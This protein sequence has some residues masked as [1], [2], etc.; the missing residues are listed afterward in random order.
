MTYQLPSR[1]CDLRRHLRHFNLLLVHLNHQQLRLRAS[2]CLSSS[3]SSWTGICHRDASFSSLVL[4][5]PYLNSLFLQFIPVPHALHE[6]TCVLRQTALISCSIWAPKLA[7]ARARPGSHS[8]AHYLHLL[9]RNRAFLKRPSERLPPA[10]LHLP[11]RP[12]PILLLPLPLEHLV[13]H[14]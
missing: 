9:H 11:L 6:Q 14:Q 8:G 4:Q 2:S 12:I 7:K 3:L 10:D 1:A 5:L 13:L